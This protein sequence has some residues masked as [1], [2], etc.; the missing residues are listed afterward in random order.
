LSNL[1]EN[2]AMIGNGRS[3]ALV[4]VDGSIDWLCLP[5]FSDAACFAALLGSHENGCWSI[6]PVG[7]FRPSRRYRGD[8]MVL[9]T[10]FTMADGSIA[11]VVDFMPR[12][13]DGD[14][15][16]NIDLVRIV[17]GVKGTVRLRSDVALRFNYGK[18]HPWVRQ[19]D[20][21]T[22]TATAGH[23]A[24]VI[25]AGVPLRG[26]DHRADGR[27]LADLTVTAGGPDVTFVMTYYPSH[28]EMPPA[29]DAAQLE[30][31]T[32]AYWSDWSAK[33]PADHPYR[34]AV[35]RSLLSLKALAYEPTGGIVAAPTTAL[36]EE[37]GGI[38]NWDYRYTWIRDASLTLYAL[39]SAGYTAEVD[40]WRRWILRAAAGRP[41]EVQILYGIRGER[42][43][44][45]FK[46]DW[47]GGYGGSRPVHV[48]NA[49]ST[50]FQMDVYGQLMSAM[51]LARVHTG[52]AD[53]G[54]A[55]RFQRELMDYVEQNWHRPDQGLWEVRGPARHFTQSKVMAWTAVDRCI[56]AVEQFKLDGPVEHWRTLREQIRAEVHA[57]GFNKR[58]N[59]FAQYYGGRTLDAALLTLPQTGFI[60]ATDPRFLGTLA[61]VEKRLMGPGGFLLRYLPD[62][63]VVGMPGGECAFLPCSFWLASAYHLVGRAG[64][65]RNLFD[66]LLA[67][68]ND[69]GLLSEEYDGK[70]N[71]LMGNFPQAFTHAALSATANLLAGTGGVDGTAPGRLSPAAQQAE[72]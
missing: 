17:R 43:L 5:S 61:A 68:R 38:K 25:R 62:E 37:M 19:I 9:E 24:V 53:D 33:C 71:H 15:R 26:G 7:D 57:K 64:D 47:L 11:L 22:I 20:P 55:W 70:R 51:H 65:A 18:S 56:R 8:T 58:L 45:D 59:S 49:A 32:V 44:P 29:R 21:T 60:E 28:R 36:P 27:T 72:A 34:E 10:A 6:A 31:T 3:A 1:I 12:P 14:D 13:P 2:Y 48:G 40:A 54:D 50:Q 69:V 46:P 39:A 41:Q 42:H 30:R 35:I 4:G 67:V 16:P 63:A 66:Q 52:Q 23:E